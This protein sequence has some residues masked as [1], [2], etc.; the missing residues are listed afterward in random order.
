MTDTEVVKKTANQRL[1]DRRVALAL[2]E[3]AKI[4]ADHTTGEKCKFEFDACVHGSGFR[5]FDL[6]RDQ[7][8][9]GNAL[10]TIGFNDKEKEI[11]VEGTTDE[12]LARIVGALH[13]VKIT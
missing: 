4:V 11:S 10:W 6:W 3:V 7:P 13:E 1:Y 5:S 9:V 8:Y 2:A 12:S